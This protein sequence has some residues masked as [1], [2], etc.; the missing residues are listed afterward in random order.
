MMSHDDQAML[1]FI[2]WIS[3][4]YIPTGGLQNKFTYILRASPYFNAMGSRSLKTETNLDNCDSMT[5]CNFLRRLEKGN[6]V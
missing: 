6:L 5:L 2:C 1:F 3:L 4:D